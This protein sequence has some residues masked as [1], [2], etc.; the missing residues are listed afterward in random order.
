MCTCL[1]RLKLRSNPE[2]GK[3]IM[4]IFLRSCPLMNVRYAH[5]IVRHYYYNSARWFW[6]C[7]N[8]FPSM[9]QCYGFKFMCRASTQG[10]CDH[11]FAC[12]T[13][14]SSFKI[15]HNFRHKKTAELSSFDL[16]PNSQASYC[17]HSHTVS[18]MI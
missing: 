2:L 9:I 18:C 13:F 3:I 7:S 4:V 17:C 15:R 6:S 5:V 8:S 1:G 16:K 11:P 14:F 12:F 10:F